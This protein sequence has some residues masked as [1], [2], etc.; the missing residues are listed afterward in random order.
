MTY[1]KRESQEGVGGLAGPPRPLAMFWNVLKTY[2]NTQIILVI[3]YKHPLLHEKA[4]D[5]HH[6]ALH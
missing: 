6:D 4:S 5:I 2:I 1:R 3:T